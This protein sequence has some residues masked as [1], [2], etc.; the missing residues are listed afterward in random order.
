MKKK[1]GVHG[2][3]FL[4]KLSPTA[5]PLTDSKMGPKSKSTLKSKSRSEPEPPS[6]PGAQ[7]EEPDDEDDLEN[8]TALDEA[9]DEPTTTKKGGKASTK[10][11]KKK[12]ND[13]EDDEAVVEE[14]MVVSKKVT[15][16]KR[17]KTETVE[18]VPAEED[19][20]GNEEEEENTDKIK[21]DRK[22]AKRTG[23]RHLAEQC[24]YDP[25]GESFKADIHATAMTVLDV[26]RLVT[27]VPGTPDKP[28]F[29]M[30]ELE[31]RM[32]LYGESLPMGAARQALVHIEH[33]ARHLIDQ[34][35]EITIA[36]G[37]QTI[38]PAVM[39]Q[40][41]KPYR[42][43]MEFSSIVPPI[44]L[45]R[46]AKSTPAQYR[47]EYDSHGK[48]KMVASKETIIHPYDPSVDEKLRKDDIMSD[49]KEADKKMKSSEAKITKKCLEHF[50]NRQE[51][52]DRKKSDKVSKRQKT[53]A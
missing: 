31:R 44:G 45:V 23:Y 1:V 29:T 33:A 4:A 17:A 51:Q 20:E 15:G 42:N 7:R 10:G 16:K 26:K 22:G 35:V 18:E 2:N 24:G 50:N 8:M 37:V 48:A 30:E 43:S 36:K 39:L 25:T 6:S 5:A 40:V 27:F 19:E 41:L 49:Y 38:S 47:K 21:R 13:D 12:K 9:P 28:S 46:H 32:E 3:V 11:K 14:D 53:T 52:I 34:A